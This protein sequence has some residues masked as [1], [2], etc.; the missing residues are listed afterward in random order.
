MDKKLIL[1]LLVILSVIS[2]PVLAALEWTET[3]LY[4]NVAVSDEV[5]VYLLQES[6]TATSGAGASTSQNIEFNSTT[7]TTQW[8][9]ARVQGGSSTLQNDDEGIIWIDNTGST[10]PELNISV[11]VSSWGSGGYS[12]LDLHY[13]SN[14]TG[15]ATVANYSAGTPANED[16]LNTTNVTLDSSF[17]PA[18]DTWEV[19]LWGNF[20]SCS[21]GSTGAMLYVWA[22]FP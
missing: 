20:S 5:T 6:G 18:E 14:Q 11:N 19:W 10:T 2:L 8:A 16:Q 1:V 7:G 22:D 13:F 4:F 12:C 9:N 17:T 21:S 15:G 3:L